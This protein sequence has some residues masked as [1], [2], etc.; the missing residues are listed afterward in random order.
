M[1]RLLGKVGAMKVAVLGTGNMGSSIAG[2]L[3][4]WEHEVVAW[5]RTAARVEP[6]VARGAH[7]AATVREAADSVQAVLISV[8]DDDAA[9]AVITDLVTAGVV[10]PVVN[11]TTAGVERTVGFAEA[12]ATY[13]AAPILGAPQAVANGTA[14][15]LVGGP[16]DVVVKLDELWP[17]LTDHVQMCGT[18]PTQAVV[19]KLISNHLL[20]TG[21]VALSEAVAAGQAAGLDDAMLT[22]VL[23]SSPMLAAGLR[24]RLDDVVAGD[25]TNGWF[26]TP[27]GAKDLGLFL[28][29]AASQD[30]RPPL[31]A[32]ARQ[33][34]LEAVEAGLGDVDVA[35]VVELLRR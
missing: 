31:A 9:A 15:Y 29:L 30:V 5:N 1:F 28:D 20:L 23:G 34:Y 19:V 26:D 18:D 32:A 7:A 17:A 2:R 14:T 13:V 27:L 21:L 25:H 6:L 4:D 22:E 3:L 24:N 12:C 33:R 11:C 10:V 35:A 16:A 8:R